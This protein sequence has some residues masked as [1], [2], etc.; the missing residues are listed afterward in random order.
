MTVP[1]SL[2][3]P[4]ATRPAPPLAPRLEGP[5]LSPEALSQASLNAIESL[6]QAGSSRNT[7]RSYAAALRYWAAW[8][9]L[10]Y[11]QSLSLPVPLPVVLQFVVDHA[12]RDEDGQR[13]WELPAE[14]DAQLVAAGF[15][16]APGPLALSTVQHRL[17]VLSQAHG[18]QGQPSPCLAPELREL[19]RR[20]RRAQTQLAIHP[21]RKTALSREPLE[22]LLATCDDSLLGLR[23]RALLLFAW[24]SGGRRRSE[25][26][27]ADMAR[28]QALPGQGYSYHLA[29]SKNNQAGEQR[30]ENLKPI[31][32]R[33]AQALRAWLQAS[34]VREGA[35]F[36]RVTK[37]GRVL[38]PLPD[39][40]VATIVK[41]R[42]ALA[43][44]EGDFSAHSLRS[45]FIT[46]A[47]RANIP[48]PEGMAMSSH[49]SV[50]T[51]LGYY[52]AGHLASSRAARLLE[53]PP[54]DPGLR[55]D[56]AD[57]ADAAPPDPPTPRKTPPSCRSI[58]PAA[59]NSPPNC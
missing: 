16:K 11:E 10:R 47:G 12:E 50:K 55:P 24:A 25:V 18:L 2:P 34:G 13:R 48:I 33:A 8:F 14:A 38:G 7:E 22:A 9:Q 36:R 15:K 27:A 17:A 5:V 3:R 59:E 49:K 23:D 53:E 20:T 40:A 43:G 19:L 44:V 31:V 21:S 57:R 28:L 30:P 54:H 42:C 1:E 58:S 29:S 39:K 46:E 56:R 41:Q 37:T 51:F 52:Q 4:L 26:A 6:L 45:G 35:I 32:G